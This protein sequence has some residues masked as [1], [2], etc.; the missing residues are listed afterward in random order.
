METITKDSLL[1]F[2]T[3]RNINFS[4]QGELEENYT[5][6]S[7]FHPIKNGFYYFVGHSLKPKVD[8]SLFLIAENC[9]VDDDKSNTFIYINE[10]PKRLFYLYLN[11][12]F[13]FKSNGVISDTAKIHPDAKIGNNVQIGDFCKIEECV[14]KDNVI[15]GDNSKIHKNSVIESDTVIESSSIIGTHGLAWT[16]DEN[17]DNKILQPQLG[18][19]FIGKN[20]F[21]GANTIIVRG[22]LN[23]STSIG[24]NVFI[25][26][27]CSIGHGTFIGNG[28]HFANNIT[29]AGNV[30]IGD[31]SFVGSGVTIRPKVDL[32]DR[33]IVGAGAVVIKNTTKIGLTLMGVPAKEYET[34]ES[35]S[36]MPKPKQ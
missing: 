7:I 32:D 11:N 10:D 13:R 35:P 22:S 20:S 3:E 36:G 29:T 27:G 9:N 18:G 2:L 31:Y 17:Q 34:K 33:T 16:W 6:A 24:D 21:L 15:I 5:I 12:H 26:N 1:L 30:K 28:V 8:K 25:A 4:I 19:V 23:E 14:I